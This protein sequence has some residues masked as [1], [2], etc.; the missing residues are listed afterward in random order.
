[1]AVLD[2]PVVSPGHSLL[3][4]V[5][6]AIMTAGAVEAAVHHTAHPHVVPHLA[7][8][9]VLPH[10]RHDASQLVAGHTGVVGGAHVVAG[11]MDVSVADTTELQVKRDIVVSGTLKERQV[12]QFARQ[13]RGSPAYIP[14]DLNPAE[15]GVS[16]RL[17]PGYGAVHLLAVT[18]LQR[19]RYFKI[20]GKSRGISSNGRINLQT[21][22]DIQIQ[23]I[24]LMKST[25]VISISRFCSEVIKKIV[26]YT[27]TISTATLSPTS[28]S[29][30][31]SV[32]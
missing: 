26:L 4:H 12:V 11:N 20:F 14:C 23:M 31:S 5:L 9:H 30:L 21:Y 3:A 18:L 27:I 17:G 15:L 1:M 10:G 8:G 6:L 32:L 7:L 19:Q 25:I 16:G 29:P 24:N 22:V 13:D 2:V 28:E